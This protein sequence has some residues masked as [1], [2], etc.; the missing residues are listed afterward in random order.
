[1]KS[2][3]LTSLTQNDNESY[4]KKELP[5][6]SRTSDIPFLKPHH[7]NISPYAQW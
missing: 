7:Q 2:K 6:A 4:A 5:L 3:N 1:M